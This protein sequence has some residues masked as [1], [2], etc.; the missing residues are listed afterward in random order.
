[1]SSG[2]GERRFS[3]AEGLESEFQFAALGYCAATIKM[4][5]QAD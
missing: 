4:S 1:M 5:G 2:A 3:S